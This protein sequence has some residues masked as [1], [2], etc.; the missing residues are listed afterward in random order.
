MR[1][2]RVFLGIGLWLLSSPLIY[3]GPIL[4]TLN[5]ARFY[6]ATDPNVSY[7]CEN[8]NGVACNG[9]VL[10]AG[11]NWTVNYDSTGTA[12]FGV[13]RDYASVFLTGDNSLGAFP[14]LESTGAR[15]GYQDT[16]TIGGGTGSGTI[17][18]TFQVAGT[19]TSAGG[20]LGSDSFQYV[21]VVGGQ[22]Q[23][24][25][26]AVSYAVINGNATIPV[27]FTFGQPITFTIYFYALAQIY[28]WEAGSSATAAFSDTAV[29][30]QIVVLN[31]QGQPVPGFTIVSASGTSYGADGVVPELVLSFQWSALFCCWGSFGQEY[32]PIG[33]PRA[34]LS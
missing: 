21:P 2:Q 14:S 10:A 24:G 9:S 3:S 7:A 18:F 1:P 28:T 27:S 16:Y 4:E 19:A 33:P 8:T 34:F 13:L 29:L 25:S 22:E 26:S 23:F 31:S 17:D 12:N 11:T 32:R 30:D 5:Y 15:S 6:V 20:G